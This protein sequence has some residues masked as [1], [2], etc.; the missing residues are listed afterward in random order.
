MAGRRRHSGLAMKRGQIVTCALQG[1][2]GKP[3]PALVIQSDI[4]NPV[5][6]SITICQITSSLNEAPA[7]RIDVQPSEANG[8]KKPSQI[9]IDKIQTTPRAKIGKVLGTL[10]PAEMEH[11][12][13]ALARWVGLTRTPVSLAR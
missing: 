2:Y 8:L 5:H 7:F 12:N 6:S 4:F 11:V 10:S 1:D 3:R 9:M 13:Q